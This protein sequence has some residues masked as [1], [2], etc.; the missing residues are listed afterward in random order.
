[1]TFQTLQGFLAFLYI[2]SAIH[3]LII[4][5][6]RSP[7]WGRRGLRRHMIRKAVG[8][9]TDA[10]PSVSTVSGKM[11]GDALSNGP[12]VV[13]IRNYD[14]DTSSSKN[15]SIS[16]IG[17]STTGTNTTENGDMNSMASGL[18]SVEEAAIEDRLLLQQRTATQGHEGSGFF[19]RLGCLREYA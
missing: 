3:L 19:L 11:E 16:D 13:R 1:M 17:D 10:D 7:R 5:I 6:F 14:H 18:D 8:K 2:G 12:L 15:G 9:V 4:I